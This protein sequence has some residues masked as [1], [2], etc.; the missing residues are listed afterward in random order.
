MANVRPKADVVIIGMGWS[1]TVIAEELSRAGLKVVGIERGVWRD[2]SDFPPAVSTDELRWASRKEIM[3]PPNVEAYSFRN[4]SSQEAL[5]VREWSNLTVGYNVGGAGTHWA[6]A[7]WRYTPSDLR[8]YSN[9]IERYGKKQIVEGLMLQDW[10][11]TYEELEPFYDRF[12]RIAGTAGKAGVINGKTVPGGNPF[13]GSRSNEYPTPPTARSHWNDIFTAKTTELGYHPFPVPAGTVSQAYVNPLG[14]HMGPCTLCGYC[15]QFGC[16]NWSKSSPNACVVPALMRSPNFEMLTETD[17]LHINKADDGKTATGVTFI[18]RNGQVTEQPADIVIVAAYQLDNVRLMLLSKIGKPY[19]PVTNEGTIGR[20][21]SFQTL[22]Y[23]YLWFEKE[24]LNPFINTGA[25]AVQIDDFN[26]DNFDHTGLGFIGGA[27]IQSLSNSGLP[28]GFTGNLPKGSP[29][30]GKGWKQSFQHAYQNWAM[31]QGQGTSYSSRG[32]YFDLDPT[33]RD[34]YGRPLLRMTY[35]YNLNDRRSG[36]F[37]RQKCEDI[38]KAVGGQSVESYNFAADHYTP[39]RPNDSSHTIGGVVM[40]DDPKTSALNRYQQSWDAH[41]VFVL[42]ASSFPNNAGY[43]PTI[44]IGAL[45][46]WTAKAIIEQYVK[47]P[48]P[49]VKV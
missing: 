21:Y 1:G 3:L 19:D 41:N 4:N 38:A 16:A 22:S 15:Q 37:V 44:T 48:G 26:G 18:T 45:A 24:H 9:T 7:S 11:V 23:A 40:G 49:L 27:G 30:W 17:V 6:A 8:I 39:Y 42:G 33:Y 14:I 34:S 31:I 20:N 43:N 35:D 5:P 12:E 32:Q 28:I 36:E 10:G 47:A 2:T 25:M 46:L 13:E 29:K